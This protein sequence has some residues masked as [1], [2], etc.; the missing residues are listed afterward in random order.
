[1]THS[2]RGRWRRHFAAIALLAVI[3]LAAIAAIPT[4][5]IIALRAAGH[6]LVAD[7]PV[8]AADLV[9]VSIDSGNAGLLEAADLVRRGVAP[10]AAAFTDLLSPA[11]EEL[12]RRGVL[13]E[14]APARIERQLRALGVERVE[15]L[16]RVSGTEEEGRV[17]ASWCARQGV[18]SVVVVS[19]ADHSRRVRRVL[20]RATKASGLVVFVRRAR[21]SSFNPDQWWTTREGLRTE[22]VELQKLLLDI[23]RH[24]LP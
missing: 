2:P 14:E 12:R 13:D 23:L 11:D 22:I 4:T 24:P 8:D 9:V 7:D 1:M 21:F 6:A 3:S 20:R 17:L 15:A 16:P 19:G 10:R 18:R 5:R